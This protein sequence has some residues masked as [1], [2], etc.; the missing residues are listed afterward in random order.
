MEEKDMDS[1]STFLMCLVFARKPAEAA[2]RITQVVHH[3]LMNRRIFNL[4]LNC[5]HK[6]CCE[7][8]GRYLMQVIFD[9]LS[10]KLCHSHMCIIYC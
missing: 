1:A 3:C 9:S 8:I 5:S 4:D 6:I 10:F 7:N 2:H